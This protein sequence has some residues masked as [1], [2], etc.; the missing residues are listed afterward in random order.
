M[1]P[2]W[3][4]GIVKFA[5][6]F[7]TEDGVDDRHG[8]CG[9][10]GFDGGDAYRLWIPRKTQIKYLV[11]LY[12]KNRLNWFL[13]YIQIWL[14]TPETDSYVGDS[15]RVHSFRFHGNKA[16][17]CM[18]FLLG[19]W[20]PDICTE[21]HKQTSISLHMRRYCAMVFFF[22]GIV[23]LVAIDAILVNFWFVHIQ[24]CCGTYPTQ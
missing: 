2:K 15:I 7:S 19:I 21:F 5:I 23:C 22:N 14:L 12:L 17:V 20:I 16:A 18:T 4:V 3:V 8:G 1:W 6:L 10:C 11:V 13:W 24:T 9:W